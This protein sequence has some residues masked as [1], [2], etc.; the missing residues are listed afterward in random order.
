I[1][2][3]S[4]VFFGERHTELLPLF[5]G[6]LV[7]IALSVLVGV[8]SLLKGWVFRF[9]VFASS[10]TVFFAVIGWVYAVCFLPLGMASTVED[11]EWSFAG[12]VMVSGERLALFAVIGSMYVCGAT[13]VHV[14][15]LRK[16]LR[17]GHSEKRTMG[18]YLAASSVY[19]SKSLWIIF[20][21]AVTGPNVLTGGQY[22]LVTVGSLGFLLFA[23]VLTSLPV[24]FG[25]L[26]YLKSR[27]KKYWE[28]RPPKVVVSRAQKRAQKTTTLKKVGKWTLI[29]LAVIVVIAVLNEVLPEIL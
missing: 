14:L 4:M 6:H 10:L 23:S 20:G 13:F 5:Y 29:A 7:V 27:D 15:L 9:Q 3:G 28:Q 16:R 22:V 11:P 24:E 26:T 12:G 17:E 18:N 1:P 21:V 2:S 8:L 19:S 25:Y